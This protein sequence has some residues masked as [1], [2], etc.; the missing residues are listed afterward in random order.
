MTVSFDAGKLATSC[1][2]PGVKAFQLAFVRQLCN[3]CGD[4]APSEMA[5]EFIV[6]WAIED[7]VDSGRGTLMICR[8]C[9]MKLVVQVLD[10][11]LG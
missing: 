7:A 11:E 10:A 1:E 8:A 4:E 2:G 6:G 5:K 3:G 9:A